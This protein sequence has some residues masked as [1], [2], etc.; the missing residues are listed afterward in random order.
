MIIYGWNAKNIKQA[1]LGEAYECPDCHQKQS[2][3]AIFAHYLHI[4]WIPLFPLRKRAHI[5]CMNCGRAEKEGHLEGD[6]KQ[7]VRQLKGAVKIPWWMFSGLG[8]IL[9]VIS[10]YFIT[11]FFE[12]QASSSKALSP[13]VGDVYVIHNPEETSEYDHYLMKVLT[14]S[15]DSLYVTVT[16]YS[17]NGI[18]DQLAPEDGF[19]DFTFGIH[20]D[21]IAR[22]DKSGEL[23]RVYRYYDSLSGFDRVIE[24]EIPEVTNA[25]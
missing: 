1:P 20:K 14:V 18:V 13:K 12:G 8:I 4:F 7:K 23:K 2:V 19:Y 5:V 15:E 24:Y 21:E 10:S 16:S 22:Q 6:M 25:E 17:Y 3:L 9:I 11:E